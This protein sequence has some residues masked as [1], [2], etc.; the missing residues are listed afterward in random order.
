MQ[1]TPRWWTPVPHVRGPLQIGE[2]PTAD[3][4]QWLV[5][6]VQD[7]I[8]EANPEGRWTYLNPA[9]Q[10]VLGHAVEDSLGQPF[11][12]YVHPDD[13]QGNLDVFVE[14]LT[15]GKEKC[16]YEARYLTA[17]GD[18]RWMEINAWIFRG[19]DGEPLGSTG[20]LTDV[21][22]RRLAEL[23]LERRATHDALTGLPNRALLDRHLADAINRCADD[24][25]PLAL[26]FL[27]L[28]RFKLV[29][30]TLG[31]DVG[32]EV[33]RA[34]SERLNDAVRPADLI[35]RFG[36]D[37]F[38]VIAENLEGPALR[39]YTQRLHAALGA[40]LVVAGRELALSTS[41]GASLVSVEA[42][43][44]A[45]A[46][47][48][49]TAV[50][51]ELLRDADSAMYHAKESGRD[52]T[53]IFSSLTRDR[54]VDRFDTENE[55]RRAISH[56]ELALVYQPQVDLGSGRIVG[57]EALVRWD[58]P[59]RGRLLPAAFMSVAEES[60]LVVPLG[61]WVLT[62][63]CR[64]MV[65]AARFG[66]KPLRVA[67]NL[68]AREVSSGIVADLDGILARTGASPEHLCLEL[69]E[70][71]LLAD[72]D[73]AR[74]IMSDLASLGVC[75]S[76]DDFGTGYSSLAYLQKLP[77]GELKIDRSFVSHVQEPDG[78]ALVSAVIR[79]ADSLDLDTVAEG[80][81]RPDHVRALADLGCSVGQGFL[82]GQPVS[83]EEAL[84]VRPVM[85]TQRTSS[86]L[87]PQRS[88]V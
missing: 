21:T 85:P 38:V 13:R 46:G 40:Q 27:D 44:A 58:H 77:L 24:Q 33:L 65:T 22:D 79:L 50:A 41:I 72:A 70:S 6:S 52:R 11:L 32:D 75:L 7:V 12:D 26:L 53:E 43:T 68:S 42:V 23:E 17:S 16:R 64:A 84:S 54:I 37:E 30:D 74:L 80:I 34:V 87:H 20:T 57:L 83:L 19:A 55:L 18:V 3:R 2:Q 71:T 63:A 31:H 1:Q 35:G 25:V 28:D 14:T 5:E 10:R 51:N 4:Y 86:S 49:V 45:V 78:R 66:G 82:F 88:R 62:E 76:L 9:W 48:T 60:G 67:V 47:G 81:E 8:F 59:Q 56:G 73:A 39:P 61:R 36:G 29:N 15:M 69:T